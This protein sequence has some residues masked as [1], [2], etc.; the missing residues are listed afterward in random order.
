M[1]QPIPS[2]RVQLVAFAA[3]LTIVACSAPMMRPQGADTVRGKLS[4]LQADPQ[5]ASRAPV[6][7]K[8]A[9]TAVIAAEVDREDTALGQHLVVVADRKVEIAVA[10]AQTRLAE[11]ERTLL[12]EQRESAR[13]ASRTR[14]VDAARSD[15]DVA[16][17]DSAAARQH[18]ADLQAQIAELNARATERG[19][20][21]T[22][23]DL[24]FA[25]GRSELK[26]GAPQHLGKLAAFLNEYP[27]RSV[28]IEGHTDSVGE[29]TYNLDLSQRRADTVRAYL[30]TQ[31]IA[32]GRLAASGR[33]EGTPTASNDSASGRQQNRRVEVII[34]NVETS[35]R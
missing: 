16:R 5:L 12:S 30:M 1:N 11:D 14:E 17:M 22:L 25:S 13:L 18:A 8:E 32:A 24:L 10:R 20:V 34:S 2:M 7:I 28:V 19:L 35:A 33:G 27:D 3:A 15:A 23:G 31:G 29:E 21:V 26:G 9:E 4:R 6:A